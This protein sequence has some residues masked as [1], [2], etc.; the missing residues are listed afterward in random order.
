MFINES[1]LPMVLPPECYYAASHY[2][3]ERTEIFEPGWHCVGS[4]ADLPDE[5]SF[6]TTALMGRPLI[7]WRT[8]EGIQAF[9]N[10]CA[11]RFS[12]LKSES[13]GSASRL[14]C[15]YHGWEYDDRGETCHIPDAKSF[16]P[17]GNTQRSLMKFAT[18]TC[19]NLV[20]VRL[21]EHGPSLAEELGTGFDQLAEQ[22]DGDLH[23]CL[24]IDREFDVNWKV[25]VENAIESY[26]VDCVHTNTFGRTPPAEFCRHRLEDRS[27]A[28]EVVPPK[29]SK[30][31]SYHRLEGLVNS[32]LG[33]DIQRS[34]A[35]T[36][37]YPNILVGCERMIRSL[38]LVTPLSATRSRFV[39][40]LFAQKS[41]RENVL[42]RFTFGKL[43]Q[44]AAKFTAQVLEED[45]VVWPG[46]QRAIA[47][48]QLPS[49][50]LISVR[51]ERVFHF[52]K[53]VAQKTKLTVQGFT[54]GS[55]EETRGNA[56]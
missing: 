2:E 45:A 19:A 44:H 6:F 46:L 28:F 5:N 34:Y 9:L 30:H 16:R 15:P 32:I 17:L 18:E 33:Y 4:F 42:A 26:H 11:H 13:C 43:C 29:H 3:R 51:E 37:F 1:H 40:H 24:T 50:G 31:K 49:G 54:N 55:S 10:V 20:F 21:T 14:K 23:K 36:F 27:T 38:M 25:I 39:F 53:Y 56:A 52:Q 41:S 8:G 35:H 12:M 22:F 47:S 7:V 48:P